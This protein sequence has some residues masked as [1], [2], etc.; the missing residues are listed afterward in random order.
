MAQL[1]LKSSHNPFGKF[2]EWLLGLF[3]G[4]EGSTDNTA[5][6]TGRHDHETILMELEND[7]ELRSILGYRHP[8]QLLRCHR[9]DDGVLITKVNGLYRDR[10]SPDLI[11]YLCE[12]A[13]RAHQCE[14]DRL[15]LVFDNGRFHTLAEFP[16][17]ELW[18]NPRGADWIYQPY[19]P[20][21]ET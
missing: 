4:T 15:Y 18:F 11:V 2:L 6:R 7:T 14:P 21:N 9:D 16:T 13:E 5:P 17:G 19:T 20:P 3:L 10:N 12:H 1:A 8:P